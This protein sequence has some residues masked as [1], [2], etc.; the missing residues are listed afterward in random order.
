MRNK[1]TQNLAREHQQTQGWKLGV[2]YFTERQRTRNAALFPVVVLA[3]SPQ[4]PHESSAAGEAVSPVAGCQ[5][6]IAG[7]GHDTNSL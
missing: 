1:L 3:N 4:S 7:K 5:E 2:I 6:S